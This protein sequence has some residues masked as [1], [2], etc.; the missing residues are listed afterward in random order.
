VGIQSIYPQMNN[1]LWRS[2]AALYYKQVSENK[3][4]IK[5]YIAILGSGRYI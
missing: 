3:H 1:L 2:H 4:N 5:P